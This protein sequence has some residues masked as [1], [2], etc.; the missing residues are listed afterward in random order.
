MAEYSEKPFRINEFVCSDSDGKLRPHN[1]VTGDF[2]RISSDH[3][4]KLREKF[5]GNNLNRTPA[6]NPQIQPSPAET[7]SSRTRAW[8]AAIDNFP[9]KI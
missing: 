8:P 7:E 6:R 3:G 9:G 2:V 1:N 5:N 4:E